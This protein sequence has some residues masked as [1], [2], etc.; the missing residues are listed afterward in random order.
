MERESQ[1][2]IP[3]PIEHF[4]QS[5]WHRE[6]KLSVNLTQEFTVA[7]PR[8][9]QSKGKFLCQPETHLW[10]CKP[11]WWSQHCLQ[12]LRADSWS[13]LEGEAAEAAPVEL[14]PGNPF[15]LHMLFS[16]RHLFSAFREGSTF[17]NFSRGA[18]TSCFSYLKSKM[19]RTRSG[20]RAFHGNL[21]VWWGVQLA[22]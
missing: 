15:A 12:L 11:F 10:L 3:Q 13:E 6:I 16:V 8:D 9:I 17:Q 21:A 2:E 4:I 22:G 14:M 1:G 18:R 7:Q 20:Q 5:T 19:C